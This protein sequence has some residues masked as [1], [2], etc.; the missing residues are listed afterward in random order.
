MSVGVGVGAVSSIVGFSRLY[1]NVHWFSDVLGAGMLGVF[2]LSFAVF[3]FKLLMDA[4]KL[5]SERF[6]VASL[7][8]FVVAVIVVFGV[9]VF[10]LL[11]F[12]D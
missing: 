2:W 3:A 4:G 10:G 9:I 6:R 12:I 11:G 8:L 7:P 5:G 1:L